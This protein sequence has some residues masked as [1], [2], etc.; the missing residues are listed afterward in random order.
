MEYFDKYSKR[1]C[2]GQWLEPAGAEQGQD[3][4]AMYVHTSTG[5]T[6]FST[7]QVKGHLSVRLTATVLKKNKMFRHN[8]NH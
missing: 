8:V 3:Y 4:A 2:M 1:L 6:G 7:R 5:F